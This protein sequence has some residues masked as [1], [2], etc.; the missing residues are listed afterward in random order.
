MMADSS[1]AR[2]ER[3]E[4]H[5][6]NVNNIVSHL[7][8]FGL[9]QQPPT[10]Q[11]APNIPLVNPKQTLNDLMNS[12]DAVYVVC[13]RPQSFQDALV[14]LQI[15]TKDKNKNSPSEEVCLIFSDGGLR[16]RVRIFVS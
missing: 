12:E 1:E 4:Q 9:G 16:L 7:Y 2:V 10:N 13:S 8:T 15:K 6:P 5:A 11:L 14:S 3:D